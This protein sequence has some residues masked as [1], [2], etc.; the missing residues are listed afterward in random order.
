MNIL[1]EKKRKMEYK[2]KNRYNEEIIFIREGNSIEMKGGNYYRY[3]F[4]VDEEGNFKSYDAID[5]SG[6]PFI[7]VGMDM[8]YIHEDLKGLI[9]ESIE[10]TK[11]GE[12]KIILKTNIV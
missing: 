10:K 8:E 3:L 11:E 12:D 6:G 2:F 1:N 7:S 5:P 4:T 9:I